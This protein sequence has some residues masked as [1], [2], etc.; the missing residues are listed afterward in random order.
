MRIAQVAP[1]V[2]P[3]PTS[4]YGGVERVVYHLTDQLLLQGHHVTLLASGTSQTAAELLP[5]TSVS[6]AENTDMVDPAAFYFAQLACLIENNFDIVHF[7]TDLLASSYRAARHAVSLTT[8]HGSVLNYP[9]PYR[10]ILDIPYVS[11]SLSQRQGFPA[12]NWCANIPNGI[13]KD[14][15]SFQPQPDGYLSFLGRLSPHKGCEH[16]IR[17]ARAAQIPLKIAGNIEP[18]YETYFREVLRPQLD[19]GFIEY[20]G[21]IGDSEK[22]TFLG[23]S[24]ALLFPI[25]WSEPFGLVVIEALACGTPVIAYARGAIAELIDDG[26]SGRIVHS[27]SEAVSAVKDVSSISR[28]SCRMSF[29]ERFTAERMANRYA[30]LYQTVC[31][32]PS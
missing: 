1:L 18:R 12:M 31:A 29:D 11:V 14:L 25:Q 3:F 13:P 6:I 23:K 16:A 21:E 32:N 4:G 22:A 20:I 19:P 10:G 2:R 30:R 17:I 15:Y 8:A 27:E 7:H 9:Q 5:V 28:V 26:I 24:L